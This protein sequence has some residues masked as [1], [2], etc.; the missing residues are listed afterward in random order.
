MLKKRKTK[1]TTSSGENDFGVLDIYNLHTEWQK[2][3][4]LVGYYGKKLAQARLELE[5]SKAVAQVFEA[6]TARKIRRKPKV[7]GVTRLTEAAIKEAVSIELLTSQTHDV[8]INN[9]YKVDLL[10]VAM[11]RLEHRKKALTDCTML[12]GQQYYTNPPKHI[13]NNAKDSTRGLRGSRDE[14]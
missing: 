5:Q 7:Y 8:V 1:P 6:E 3:D 4:R 10:E 13:Q 14:D 11:R 2:Q 12:R 9:K